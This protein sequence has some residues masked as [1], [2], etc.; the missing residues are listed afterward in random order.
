M[1]IFHFVTIDDEAETGWTSRDISVL[2]AYIA[3]KNGI[4][5]IVLNKILRVV[6]VMAE[7]KRASFDVGRFPRSMAS[8][9]RLLKI[10]PKAH[11]TTVY[12]CP[13]KTTKRKINE[14][15]NDFKE[16]CG[17]SLREQF[18]DGKPEYHCDFCA[19]VWD[20]AIVS[21]DGN[22]FVTA[23]LHPLLTK[24]MARLG[25]L[26][27][28]PAQ[29]PDGFGDIY[30]GERCKDM[31]LSDDNFI[32]SVHGDSAAISKSTNK[33]VYLMFIRPLNLPSVIRNNLWLLHTLWVGE[34]LPKDRE[35]FLL[36]LS[37]QLNK[38]QHGTPNFTPLC[39]TDSNGKE[40]SSGVLVHSVVRVR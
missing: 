12:I 36:E 39:Y 14:A 6:S 18:K 32:I 1:I 22:H 26:S 35:C 37:K 8:L 2:L 20:K 10:S 16:V 30:D 11:Y 24:T 5:D 28:K 34:S 31:D 19:S 3:K 4:P 27:V 40:L 23:G 15:D 13:K 25:K 7:C 17:F 33:K 29:C 21:R 38:L 9:L